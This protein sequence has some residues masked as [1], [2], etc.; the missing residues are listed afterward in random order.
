MNNR[1]IFLFREVPDSIRVGHG[2]VELRLRSA[3]YKT[4]GLAERCPSEW[5]RIS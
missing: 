3:Q 4:V 5:R 2:P 1:R